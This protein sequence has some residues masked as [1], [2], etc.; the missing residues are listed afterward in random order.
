MIRLNFVPGVS[1]S[2]TRCFDVETRDG[3]PTGVTYHRGAWVDVTIDESLEFRLPREYQ[4]ELEKLVG[5]PDQF[6]RR[7]LELLC[8]HTTPQTWLDVI[9]QLPGVF[10]DGER[11]GAQ[12]LQ[13]TLRVLLGVES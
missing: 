3:T 12:A 1:G 4:Q 9:A 13:Q 6:K 8:S 2:A 7:A 5:R 10:R 11:R